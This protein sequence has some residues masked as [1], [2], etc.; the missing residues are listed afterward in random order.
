MKL[1]GYKNIS[2]T[3]MTTTIALILFNTILISLFY[4]KNQQREFEENLIMLQYENLNHQK[5]IIKKDV[6][7]IIQM[8]EYKYNDLKRVVENKNEILQWMKK[9][10]FDRTKSDYIFVYELHNKQG[11]DKF[12]KLLVNP[13][14]PDIEGKFISTNY[15]DINGFAFRKKFLEDINTKGESIVQYS[16]KKT[17]NTVGKK[18]SYF[19]YYKPLNWVVAKGVYIEDI[20]QDIEDEKQLLEYRLKKQIKQNL[21]FFIFLSIIAMIIAYI[22]GKKVQ[23]I[24]ESK[25]KKVKSKTKALANLNRKLDSKVKQ[26][27]EK[28]K[29]QQ[30]IFMQK[31]KFTALGEMISL[32]AH[33]WRQPISE[34][35]AI[36]LNLKMHH[37]LDKLDKNVMEKKTKDI[38]NI[39]EFMSTTIDNFRSF[40]KPNKEKEKFYF[41]DSFKRIEALSSAVLKENKIIL[42]LDIDKTLQ[43]ESYENEFEQ[44]ILNIITNAKDALLDDQI[45]TPKITIQVYKDEMIMV[46]VFD[47]A[48]GIRREVIDKIFDPYFTTKSETEGTGIGLYMSKMIIEENMGGKIRVESSEKGTCFIIEFYG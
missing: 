3:I 31:S 16:Y 17:N 43:L 18:I 44:V 26:E 22:I 46:K 9:I 38:E 34:L 2:R 27:I 47:N 19:Y 20:H 8:I 30:K 28:N 35:N 13:N 10:E 45:T 7:Q 1:L 39:L 25:D 29:K 23:L 37:T 4:Y 36:I 33:Q 15:T 6:N 24:I 14:R 5:K 40:F 12:A 48:K 11:G 42:D 21:F 41:I 32:I